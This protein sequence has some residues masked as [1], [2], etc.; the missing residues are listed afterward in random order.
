MLAFAI[1]AAIA[2]RTITGSRSVP[3]IA[4]MLIASFRALLFIR[5]SGRI[6][7]VLGLFV[8]VIWQNAHPSVIIATG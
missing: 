5:G 8:L 7:V 1:P 2:G 3:I 6:K 4:A